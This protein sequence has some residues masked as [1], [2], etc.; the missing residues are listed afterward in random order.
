MFT[1]RVQYPTEADAEPCNH[2]PMSEG[3]GQSISMT[4]SHLYNWGV[5]PL[6][7]LADD[8]SLVI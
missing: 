5:V 8:H 2:R 7:R 6:T 3:L 4:F 1:A